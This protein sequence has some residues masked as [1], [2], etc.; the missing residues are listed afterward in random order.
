MKK[1][2]NEFRPDEPRLRASQARI[3]S[4]QYSANRPLLNGATS[5]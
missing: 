4:H 1:F 5:R 2:V 3:F